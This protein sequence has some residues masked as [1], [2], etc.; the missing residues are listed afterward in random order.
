[1]LK[2]G[3]Y[4]GCLAGW[5]TRYAHIC[6]LPRGGSEKASSHLILFKDLNIY[7]FQYKWYRTVHIWAT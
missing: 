1:M 3:I 2:Y 5:W 7:F 4:L 6:M